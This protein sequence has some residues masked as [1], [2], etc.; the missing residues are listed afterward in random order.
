MVHLGLY[1]PKDILKKIDERRGR[2]YSRNR[3]FLKL[4]EEY[5]N[6]EDHQLKVAQGERRDEI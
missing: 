2:Y 5:L 1:F 6:K 4:I 3:Y